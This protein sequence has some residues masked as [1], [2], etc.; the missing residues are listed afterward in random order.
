MKFHGKVGF[1]VTAETDPEN[2]PGVF[3]ETW[4]EKTYDG[5]HLNNYSSRWKTTGNLNDDISFST[6]IS[7]LSDPFANGN[8]MNIRYVEWMNHLWE[9]S[10]VEVQFPRLVLNVGDL[11]KE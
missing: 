9:V 8:F 2:H 6:R 11:Y 7:I 1:L 3:E 10:S 4:V 5:E